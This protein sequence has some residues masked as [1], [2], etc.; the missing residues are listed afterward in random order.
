MSLDYLSLV[1]SLISVQISKLS[2]AL[3]FQ[4]GIILYITCT[5]LCSLVHTTWIQCLRKSAIG[6]A[7]RSI[8]LSLRTYVNSRNCAETFTFEELSH[9]CRSMLLNPNYIIVAN[10]PVAIFLTVRIYSFNIHGAYMKFFNRLL[11]AGSTGVTVYI[12]LLLLTLSCTR[13]YVSRP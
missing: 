1:F 10:I 7:T 6:L 12:A 8:S 5:F 11:L 3:H 2:S 13:A 4:S 9:H